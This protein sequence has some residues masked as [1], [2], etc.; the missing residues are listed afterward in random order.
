MHDNGNH[1]SD[2]GG[3][4][5]VMS[6][7]S[8]PILVLSDDESKELLQTQSLGRLCVLHKDEIEIFPV[9][10]HFDGTD[11]VLRTSE[12]TKLFSLTVNKDVV[13][14][15]DEVR[16]DTAWSIV[17]RGTARTLQTPE[18]IRHA[19]SLPLKPWIPTLKYNYV[20]ITP[21]QIDGREF[22]LG[23]EPERY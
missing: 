8:S 9:N 3:R 22:E 10:Y 11:I 6:E 7:N 16:E 21:T 17:I 20:A 2:I 15:V 19:D 1:A 14:E 23:E 18:E 12:G 4:L 13:F 5:Y